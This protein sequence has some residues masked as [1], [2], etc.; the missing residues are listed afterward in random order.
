MKIESIGTYIVHNNIIVTFQQLRLCSVC[1]W[2]QY[3]GSC[4]CILT[5]KTYLY[6]LIVNAY[7]IPYIIPI[8]RYLCG[9]GYKRHFHCYC[10]CYFNYMF[11]YGT[12]F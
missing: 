9:Y 7:I 5:K 2:V 4:R 8:Y 6:T 3:N 12:N 10:Y 11:Y 1:T